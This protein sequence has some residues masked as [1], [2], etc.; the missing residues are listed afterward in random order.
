[1]FS[2]FRSGGSTGNKLGEYLPDDE[3]QPY[4]QSEEIG[5]KS[6][7]EARR[8]CKEVA[9]EYGGTDADVEPTGREGRWNCKFKLWG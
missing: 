6:E 3:A 5:A 2:W 8:K 4:E 9:N 7:P 1:M